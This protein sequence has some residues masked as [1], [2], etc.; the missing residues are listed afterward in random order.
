[1]SL[2]TLIYENYQPSQQPLREAMTTLGNG[3]FATRGAFEE[4]TAGQTESQADGVHYP[5]TYLAGG[6]N[7][8]TS[9]VSGRSIENED[10]VNFPNWLP[11]SFRA[12]ES[13]EAS[14]SA[15]F[16]IDQVELL[17]FR[18]ELDLRHGVLRR[19]L[20]CKDAAGRISSLVCLRLVHMSQPHLAAIQWIFT[21][22][23]WSGPVE[24]R[25]ALD[26]TV[27]NAGVARYRQLASKHLEPLETS[28]V[29]ESGIFLMTQTTQSHLVLA[30]SACTRI[31]Q[32]EQELAPQRSLEQ[33]D[34]YIAATLKVDCRQ[35]EALRLEKIVS[36]YSSHDR[37]ISE[38]GLEARQ[39]VCRMP[40]F[41]KLFS[42]H[43]R[44]WDR[45]WHRCDLKV[46]DGDRQQLI[47]RLHIFHLLQ[48]CSPNTIDL[49]AG[50]P[51]R[52]LH[53]EAYRGHIFWD[54]LFILPFLN[55]R[56][57]ELVRSLL[58]YR[59]RR[60]PAA[61]RLAAAEGYRGAMY[62]WQ[63]GSNGQEES[64]VVH[65]NPK[66]G[67]WVPDNTY[68]QRHINASL[69][70][71]IWQYHQCTLDPE[72][73][74]RFGAPMILEIAL[75][76][77][78]LVQENPERD[79]YEIRGVVGPDEFHTKYPDRDDLGLDN[80]AYTNVMVAWVFGTALEVLDRLAADRRDELL[81]DLEI[82]QEQLNRWDRISRRMF[83]PFHSDSQYGEGI[84]SQF[85]G[86]EKLQP[87]DW[88][89]LRQKHS[90]IQRLDRL[91]EAEGDDINR[92]QASK[93]ADVLM[94]FYLFSRHELESLFS[95]LGYEIN[96]ELI[97]KNIEY[98]ND[99]TSHGSTL[100]RIVGAWVTARLDREHSWQ[101][102]LDA[103]ESDIGDIQGGTTA[104]GIHLGAMSGTVDVVQRCYTGVEIRDEVLWLAP[105][106]PQE[107]QQIELRL[108]F[109]EHWLEIL[110]NH[111]K[112]SVLC[113]AGH[114]SPI[115][116]GFRG[117][118][119]TFLPGEQK[120]FELS[121]T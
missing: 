72:F 96:P 91:L 101:L 15:W 42:S 110:V 105:V 93:Q 22:E 38:P 25:S 99:R 68:R 56:I 3:Y 79:R 63:S 1:M 73:L 9:E 95:R 30:Q 85:E 60:L 28:P 115:Q 117:E 65:L 45:L 29:G 18:I 33:R 41:Q 107:M 26:G 104:E 102:Y 78:S 37:G 97:Q 76:W 103:L 50:V 46:G 82:D 120:E 10:L 67:R 57:P 55:L 2:W 40:S 59:F 77:S 13:P 70:Y 81:A 94:L 12:A 100:S 69:V 20:R 7:R 49:D 90:N 14:A 36:V 108:H 84:I 119:H 62:P 74:S 11:L 116:I 16:Q 43:Q 31:Y 106:L 58:M 19:Q 114:G 6:Y 32:Q 8:L 23:N 87:L 27:T 48:T 53:G 113:E 17:D 109:R 5:G 83:V 111:Q 35:G 64:Q 24:F 44:A 88:E 61:R 66:S 89:A 98:Y 52:G 4:T 121:L 21:P 112:L 86:Y 34:G 51:A 92:Y 39:A 118:E 54:E 71:N 47:L 80:N 75:F